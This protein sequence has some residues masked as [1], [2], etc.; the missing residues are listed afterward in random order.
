MMNAKSKLTKKLTP[1]VLQLLQDEIDFLEGLDPP[2]KL[3]APLALLLEWYM[4]QQRDKK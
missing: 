4:E 3:A 1:T 2:D